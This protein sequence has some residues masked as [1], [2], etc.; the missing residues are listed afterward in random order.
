MCSIEAVTIAGVGLA[1]V[2]TAVT[3]YGQMQAANAQQQQ[4]N[5]A[6][7]VARNNA[8]L[9]KQAADEA[10]AQGDANAAK[11]AIAGK[12]LESRQTAV[13]ASNGVLVNNG[14]ALDIGADTAEGTKLNELG[15]EN[16]AQR[17]AIGFENQGANFNAAAA[18]DELAG[19]NS[20]AASES[21][22]FGSLATGGTQVA[23]KWYL[24]SQ[25]FP[26]GTPSVDTSSGFSLAGSD[27]SG[28]F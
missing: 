2:G 11:A 20:A 13:E 9:A 19:D 28:G 5:Y 16:N 25:Q 24:L 21:G 10:T 22:A 27:P 3:V 4:A 18:N 15:I 14:S 1:A 7:G 12:Q 23:Q 6:A 17:E 26:G 8:T